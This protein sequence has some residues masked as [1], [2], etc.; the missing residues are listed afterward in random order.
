MLLRPTSSS[1]TVLHYFIVHLN[2]LCVLN[3]FSSTVLCGTFSSV[4]RDVSQWSARMRQPL[5]EVYGA[6][7]FAKL[8]ESWVDGIAQFTHRP[9][10]GRLHV[11]AN[12][13][14]LQFKVILTRLFAHF[15]LFLCRKY[16]HG[17]SATDQVSNP[18]R[19]WRERPHGSQLPRSVSP[20]THSSVTVGAHR[21][22][23][24]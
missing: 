3:S 20:Q 22:V 2:R 7:A 13:H 21:T 1:T 5:E 14:R 12:S 16:L 17:A 9:G 8:W 15:L 18:D 19:P 4:V 23:S 6:Q 24:F 10:G 11:A